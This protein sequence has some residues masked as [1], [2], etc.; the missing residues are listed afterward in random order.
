[1]VSVVVLAIVTGLMAVANVDQPPAP[2]RTVPTVDLDRYVGEWFEIARFPNRF[3]RTCASDVRADYAR[4]TDGR[5][6]VVNRCLTEDG[7]VTEARGIA[8]VVDLDTSAKLKVRF[9]PA[10]LSFLP[11]VWGDYWILGLADDYAWAVVG[12]PD[13]RY[14][15]ILARTPVLDAERFASALAA[16]RANGFDVE[17]LM[18]TSHTEALRGSGDDTP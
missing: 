5:L 2:V 6:D 10:I 8:R 12:S 13:R 11:F 1:M 17:R 15:W 3:Q 18:T 4:R 16:V 7:G 9:A 14:L